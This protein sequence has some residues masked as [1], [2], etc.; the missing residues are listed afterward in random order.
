[1]SEAVGDGARTATEQDHDDFDDEFEPSAPESTEFDAQPGDEANEPAEPRRN[2]GELVRDGAS[3]VRTAVSNVLLALDRP[4]ASFHIVVGLTMVLTVMGVIMVLSASSVED[5]TRNGSAYG[6]FFSQVMYAVIGLVAFLVA[7]HMPMRFLRRISLFVVVVSLIL[8]VAVLVPGIGTMVDGG[9]RWIEMGPITLQPSELAKVALILWGAHLLAD[10]RPDSTLKELTVPLVPVGLLIAALIAKEPNLSTAIIIAIVVGTLLYFAGLP[11]RIF[12]SLIA[13]GV[14]AAIILAFTEGYRSARVRSFIGGFTGAAND[15]LG[16][17]YQT[18]QA[19]YSLADGGFFGVG[20]G[21][22]KAKWNYLPN[23]K[24]DFI[25]AII[26]EELGYVG[27]AVTIAMF[28]LLTWVGL[29]IARRNADPFVRLTAATITTLIATQAIINMGYVVGL[30]PVTGIQLPLLS[31]G[32]NSIIMVLFM[33]GLLA[34]A[35][36]HEPEAVAALSTGRDSRFGRWMRLPTPRPYVAPYRATPDPRR[37]K[38]RP[39]PG[40]AGPRG[41]RVASPEMYRR[42]PRGAGSYG[43]VSGPSPYDRQPYDDP[44]WGRPAPRTAGRPAPRTSGGPAPRTSGRSASVAQPWRRGG[45]GQAQGRSARSEGRSA[46][47]RA[48][49][50]D[51][52]RRS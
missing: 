42:A 50:T 26:G 30:L 16:A 9:R 47:P 2:A 28:A 36:R 15:H 44:R 10:K 45:V 8:L 5:Y 34:S 14:A 23:A 17:D 52:R 7:M 32:G 43:R 12:V 35:A 48:T 29:R 39:G 41:A 13:A 46:E 3:G 11:V 22:S 51:R 18:T 27:A 1:M 6:L 19:K 49:R 25:F 37:G 31:A 33:F 21:G 38:G 40:A 24:N 4:L 20:L